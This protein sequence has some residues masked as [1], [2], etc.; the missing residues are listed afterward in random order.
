MRSLKAFCLENSTSL[1]SK[2]QLDKFASLFNPLPAEHY[3][4]VTDKVDETTHLMAE[5]VQS[6]GGTFSLVIYDESEEV[7]EFADANV[8]H[9]KSF[10]KPFRAIPRDHDVVV[11]KNILQKHTH[12]KLIL[13][14]AYTT[15]ANNKSIIVM[16]DKGSV[17]LQKTTDTLD[18]HE[19][20][21]GNAI[22]MMDEFD[23]VVAR[24]LHMWGNGL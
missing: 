15:L 2:M 18:A 14:T 11:I 10:S 21:S 13:K 20:R 16:Q 9:I 12:P 7:I 5:L 1:T 23:V 22:E 17:D 4:Q 19:F 6:V 3:L 8:Q 24:K